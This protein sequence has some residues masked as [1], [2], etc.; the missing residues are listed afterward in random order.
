MRH[1]FV[2]GLIIAGTG[3]NNNLLREIVAAGITVVQLLRYQEETLGGV[4]ADYI[5][6]A[7][8]AVEFLYQTGSRGIG[9]LNGSKLLAPFAKRYFGYHNMIKKVGLQEN[10]I[11]L[12]DIN[13]SYFDFG[14]QKVIQLIHQSPETDAILVG[15]DCIGLGV[16]KRLKEMHKKVPK[17]YR[18]ISLAGY[19]LGKYLET[20]LSSVELPLN[21]IGKNAVEAVI[22]NIEGNF[23]VMYRVYAMNLVL[24]ASC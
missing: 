11:C 20:P 8:K 15:N 19:K 9:L 2:D 18:L 14:Y 13:S 16:L 5:H 4:G 10:F 6:A 3:G 12:P 1:S 21:K 7:M 23:D 17:D 22:G 24:R